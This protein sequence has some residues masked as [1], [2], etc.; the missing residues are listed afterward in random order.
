[1]IKRT[2]YFGNPAYLNTKNEQ[3]IINFPDSELEKITIPIEDIGI[4]ILDNYRLTISNALINKL[5]NNNVAFI[6][7]DKKHLPQGLMLNLSEGHTRQQHFEIQINTS[8]AFKNTL[9]KH[10][11]KQKI[12]NQALLLKQKDFEYKNLVYFAKNVKTGDP[13]NLEGQAAAYYWKRIFSDIV[14]DFKRGQFEEEPNNLLNYGYTIL[15]AITARALVASGLLPTFG[16]HHHNKYN[17]YCLAD[18]I[19]EPYRPFIDKLVFGLAYDKSKTEMQLTKEIKQELLKIPVLDVKI[20]NKTSPL[21][22][23]MQQTTA[24]LL[25]SMK[26]KKVELKL[27]SLI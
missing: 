27:P 5:L 10:I 11:I 20:N 12:K 7:C 23:A 9:W 6:S 1:M 22:V 13:M 17:A 3:L 8:K 4:V 2:L 18:D 21:M 14:D 24:S 25:K 15:R 26:N 19:M 16:I